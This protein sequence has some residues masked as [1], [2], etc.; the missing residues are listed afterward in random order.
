LL[1]DSGAALRAAKGVATL[2]AAELGRDG[3][4]AEVQVDEF[5]KLRRANY[6]FP[7][8]AGG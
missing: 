2:M 7:G 3:A 4:W 8:T 1:L 5:A 6:R